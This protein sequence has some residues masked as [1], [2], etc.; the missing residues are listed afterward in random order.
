MT[1]PGL[2]NRLRQHS[3]RAGLNVGVTMALAI[4]I[5]V[6][7]FAGIYAWLTPLAS[8]FIPQEDRS[9][10]APA[11]EAAGDEV[12]AVGPTPTP[13]QAEAI[14]PTPIPTPAPASEAVPTA[15]A[16]GFTPT[17]QSTSAFSVNFRAEPS[18]DSGVVTVLTPA[19]PLEY[20][21]QDA[22]TSN[23]AE[24]GNR[25]MRF[26]TQEGDEGWIREVDAE[27][28]QENP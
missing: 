20:L 16:A 26:R 24:D 11:D 15:D 6:A 23:P 27:P 8:D 10:E 2:T 9:V 14:A 22:P 19:T 1:D 17:H 21:N 25:W 13:T 12:A 3:R 4:A 7:G 18:R 28:Y 5:C